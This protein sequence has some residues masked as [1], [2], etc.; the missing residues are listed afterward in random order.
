MVLHFFQAWGRGKKKKHSD[1][2]KTHYKEKV[3]N[4]YPASKLCCL[5]ERKGNTWKLLPEKRKIKWRFFFHLIDSHANVKVT[6]FFLGV[7]FY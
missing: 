7:L 2:F 4:S 6:I 5:E 1:L 3:K